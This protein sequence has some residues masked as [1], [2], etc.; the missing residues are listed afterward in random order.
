[1]G[2]AIGQLLPGAIGVAL[3]P[4][5]IIAVILMLSTQRARVT[6]PAFAVG[7]VVGIVAVSVIVLLLAG[8]SDDPDSGASTAT[9]W[10]K[11]VLGAIFLRLGVQ[12]WH[13]R[14]RSG[15]VTPMPKWM[16]TVDQFTAGKAGGLGVLLSAVNPKNLALTVAAM[17]GVAQAGLSAGE[18]VVAVAVFVVLAS[19]TVAGPVVVYLLMGRRAEHALTSVKDWMAENNATIMFVL[20]L[21]LGM[22][23]L[24]DG[25]ADL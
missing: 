10:L 1:M 7:W 4:I 14:P 24:G 15:E 21:V 20:F 22:K 25:I 18:D 16:D 19:L 3:S 2:Q 11:I 12:Q 17:A 6:G 23:M 5:P 8:P 13:K 9:A